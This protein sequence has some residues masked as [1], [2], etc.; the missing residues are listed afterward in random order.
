MDERALAFVQTYSDK[1]T[2]LDSKELGLG[3]IDAEVVEYIEHMA[4]S[5]LLR[6]YSDKLAFSRGHPLT[7]RR[8]MWQME[9]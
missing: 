1:V 8:Y 7:V 5:T 9:Y 4:F 3:A 6:V 2:V